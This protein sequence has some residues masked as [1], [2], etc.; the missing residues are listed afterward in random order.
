MARA[1]NKKKN[2]KS[3]ESPIERWVGAALTS[4]VLAKV[5]LDHHDGDG[6]G[7]AAPG[8]APDRPAP[9][10]LADDGHGRLADSP[11]E[12]PA[13]G[14][15]DILWRT[16]KQVKADSVLM[17]SGGVAYY[18]LLAL[19]PALIALVSIYGLVASP[20][21]VATQL[22]SMTRALPAQARDLII[23]QLTA[24]TQKSSAGLGMGAVV[25]IIAA[26]W[27]A[28][29][30]M[31]WLMTALSVAYDEEETRK[32]VKLR[33]TALLLT[34]AAVVGG[35][36]ALGLLVA[37]PSVF[38]VLGLGSTG[39]MV[40]SVLRWPLLGALVLT[41]LAMLYRYGPN[42]DDPK[43]RWVTPGS[44]V[45]TVV[46]LA[47]SV[48]FSVYASVF[49]KFDKTYGALGA[50]IVLVLWLFLSAFS[51][52]L[53]AEIN[54]EVERQVSHSQAELARRA[55]WRSGRPAEPDRPPPVRLLRTS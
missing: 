39:K 36:V 12:I 44:L 26:L 2:G 49:G 38:R 48:G 17:L 54:A 41:G 23:T 40:V 19:F 52:L 30:G 32:F 51:V 6:H 33:G 16:S 22:Q 10:C 34:F 7:D 1:K 46:W 31:R 18:A 14:W 53:G 13:A 42:R 5:A 43:W 9:L 45:A 27:S 29:S 24:L 50:V 4:V 37:L 11:A 35:A 28:S 21:Q 8:A 20:S 15:K 3:G 25:S 47:A 55:E